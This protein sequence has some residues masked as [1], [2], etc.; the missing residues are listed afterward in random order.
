MKMVTLTETK[1]NQLMDEAFDMGA[2]KATKSYMR[3]WRFLRIKE[4]KEQD[5][6]NSDIMKENDNTNKNT[7]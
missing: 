3:T 4:I 6:N 2:E 1:L 7:I 5:S